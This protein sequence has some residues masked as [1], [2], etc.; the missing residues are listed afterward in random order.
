MTHKERTAHWSAIV[1]RQ[2]ASGMSGVAWC[3]EN[4]INRARFYS[5]R[6]KLSE[7]QRAQGFIEL[8]SS[9]DEY[10]GVHI[11]IGPMR[12]IEVK[13]GFDPSTLYAVIETLRTHSPCSA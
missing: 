4:Q 3:R 5:W 13:R 7:P 8:T 10:A 6:R 2:A 11:C 9:T 12:S 1:E